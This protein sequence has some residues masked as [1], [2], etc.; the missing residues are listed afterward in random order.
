[1]LG[2]TVLVWVGIVC[3]I[4]CGEDATAPLIGDACSG[5]DTVVCAQAS[6][7]GRNDK[8]AV[9]RDGSLQLLLMCPASE[10]CTDPGIPGSAACSDGLTFIPYA[11]RDGECPTDG[12]KACDTD[13]AVLLVCEGGAWSHDTDCTDEAQRCMVPEG[14]DEPICADPG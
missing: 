13:Q 7:S 2:G 5:L 1:M 8:V 11:I 14:A 3:G 9:C 12:A 4:A 6:A 10:E